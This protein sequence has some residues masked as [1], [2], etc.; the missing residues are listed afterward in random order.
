MSRESWNPEELV[1]NMIRHGARK[2][3]MKDLF[4][5]G[6]LI[7]DLTGE[8]PI[9]ETCIHLEEFMSVAARNCRKAIEVIEKIDT[10][11]ESEGPVLFT[12]LKKYV[13]DTCEAIK[14]VDTGLQ[15]KGSSISELLPE[16]PQDSKGDEASWRNLI[17]RRDV[18]AHQ[19]LTIDDQRVYQETVRDFKPLHQLLSYV[20]FV[21]VTTALESGGSGFSP[22]IK[23]KWIEGLTPAIAGQSP[24]IGTA[25]TF[26]C[27]D[28]SLGF[29]AIKLGIS[30][31]RMLF[32][33]SSQEINLPLSMF[34]LKETGLPP[35]L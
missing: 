25:L 4:R 15:S 31:Q 17:G 20:N 5:E 22:M 13:E 26:V 34:A 1:T 7:W 18:L 2:V 8:R 27:D 6:V 28:E 16:I 11:P 19:L 21:P 3:E 9:S 14:V 12:A 33:S 10:S 29:V 30:D 24:K 23:T 35:D 32:I